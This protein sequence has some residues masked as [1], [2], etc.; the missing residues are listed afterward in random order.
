MG[1]P[2]LIR[3]TDASTFLKIGILTE[4]FIPEPDLPCQ[5]RAAGNGGFASCPPVMKQNRCHGDGDSTG[6]ALV[7]TMAP[8]DL[9]KQ[10]PGSDGHVQGVYPAEQGDGEKD[11]AVLPHQGPHSL[12]FAAHDEADVAL[13]AK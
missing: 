7:G 11:I 8:A 4:F 1:P 2:M 12:P 13:E 5:R 6:A 9:M 3:G 10:D